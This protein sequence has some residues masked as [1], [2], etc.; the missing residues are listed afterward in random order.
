MKVDIFNT[1]KKYNVI[2]ADPPWSFKTWSEKGQD[3]SAEKHYQTMKVIDI[4]DLPVKD[5]AA[6]DCI[7][8]MWVTFPTIQDAFELIKAWGFEYKTCGFT[9]IKKNKKSNT[10]FWGMGYWTRSNAE[11]CLIATKGKPK[12]VSAGVHSVIESPIRRHS[13]KPDEV[14]GKIVELVGDLPRIE[15]F[16]R[17]RANDWDCWGDEV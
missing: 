1:N 13:Q 3:R 10:N 11:I 9:W 17:E 8:F 5:I 2:Y 16:A 7:L 12:R 14:R 6:D 4:C 15:L